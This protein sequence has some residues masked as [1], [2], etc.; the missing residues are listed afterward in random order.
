MADLKNL[1]THMKGG[2]V[3]VNGTV[4]DIGMDSIARDVKPEDAKKMLKSKAWKPAKPMPEEP[5]Q[6]E[7]K[8]E[9]E[10]RDGMPAEPNEFMDIDILKKMA[11]NLD[12]PYGRNI[13]K[14]KLVERIKDA[15]GE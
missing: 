7:E 10:D 13:G 9:G 15:M 11:D 3:C 5:Q 6:A 2:R 4:Y 12:V 14:S 1:H 8:D